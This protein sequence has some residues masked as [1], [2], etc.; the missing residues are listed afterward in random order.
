MLDDARVRFIRFMRLYLAI[1]ALLAVFLV[2]VF[3]SG[4]T[5]VYLR[6]PYFDKVMHVTGGFVI[7][8]FAAILLTRDIV[9][10]SLPSA[11][12]LIIGSALIVGVAWEVAEYM[13]NVYFVDATDGVRATIWRYFHGGDLKDSLLDLGADT[14]GALILAGLFLPVARRK[15]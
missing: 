1:I 9:R 4:V 2:G 7:A 5:D 13:S 15:S 11:L 6:Y 14:I 10:V 3:A 12:I 8:W